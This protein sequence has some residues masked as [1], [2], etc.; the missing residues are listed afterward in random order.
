MA[1]SLEQMHSLSGYSLCTDFTTEGL[2]AFQPMKRIAH[3]LL[4]LP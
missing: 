1:S 3:N 4:N 2:R